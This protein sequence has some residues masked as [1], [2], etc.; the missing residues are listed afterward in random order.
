[1]S[2]ST[3]D[4]IAREQKKPT[5]QFITELFNRHGSVTAV[6]VA[7]GISKSTVSISVMRAGLEC[8]T[9]VVP[10]QRKH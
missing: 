4:R 3:I 9:I 5:D 2:K 7:L 6:A 1:M 8:K 10:K